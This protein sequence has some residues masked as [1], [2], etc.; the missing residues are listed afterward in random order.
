[1]IIEELGKKVR[2]LP[3]F[4]WWP[5]MAYY[6]KDKKDN[7]EKMYIVDDGFWNSKEGR[8]K[9]KKII[10]IL[11]HAGT[12]GC[13]RKV[14]C[15]AWGGVEINISVLHSKKEDD[16]WLAVVHWYIMD[17]HGQKIPNA[18]GGF[19]INLGEPFVAH[20]LVNALEASP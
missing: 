1:M 18:S 2:A 5:G 15:D 9:D 10:P 11:D 4:L 16:K 6:Y 12:L 14:V 20:A 17:I 7:K 13:L 19:D 3:N 8:H